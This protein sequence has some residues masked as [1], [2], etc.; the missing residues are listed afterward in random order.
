MRSSTVTSSPLKYSRSFLLDFLPVSSRL[1]R[2]EGFTLNG[3]TY[4][5]HHLQS[6]IANRK[7]FGKFLLRRDPRDISRIYVLHPETQ[8]YL[9]IPCRTLNHPSLTLWEHK[10]CLHYL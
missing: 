9:E 7:T 1:L 5:S 8:E 3:I 6:L 4:F 10:A 2:R